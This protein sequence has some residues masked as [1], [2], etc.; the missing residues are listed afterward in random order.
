MRRQLRSLRPSARRRHGDDELT[1]EY[2][3]PVLTNVLLWY[4]L[5]KVFLTV[6]V[7]GV[8]V[9][10]TAFLMAGEPASIV[11]VARVFALVCAGLL[12][13]SIPVAALWYANRVHVR[14]ELSPRGVRYQTLER[15]DR[16]ANR[17]LVVLGLLSGRP[18]AVGTGLLAASR[19]TEFTR[20]TEVTRVREHATLG[21]VSLM[22]RWRVLQRLHCGREDYRRVVTYVTDH[23]TRSQSRGGP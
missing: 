4:D 20:W 11:Q 17:L 19:E 22:S 14:Y 15:R 18:A 23:V 10:A 3:L 2:R 8:A 6:Y 9:M 12:V 7:V 5:T 13:T 21:V 16:V 1:W